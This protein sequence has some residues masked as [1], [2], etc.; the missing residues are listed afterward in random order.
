V[1]K[2]E[3]RTSV[4]VEIEMGIAIGNGRGIDRPSDVSTFF[5]WTQLTTKRISIDATARQTNLNQR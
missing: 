4:I 2:K 3:G 1:L 5:V